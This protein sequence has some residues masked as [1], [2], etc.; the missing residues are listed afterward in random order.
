MNNKQKI[1]PVLLISALGAL[2]NR[3][4]GG[5]LSKGR[6][7]IS[8]W[9]E[10]HLPGPLSWVVSRL[11][12][13]KILNAIVFGLAMGLLSQHW[14]V[15]L[16]S[17]LAMLAGQAPGWGDYIGAAGGWRL[18]PAFLPEGTKLSDLA[19]DSPEYKKFKPLDESPLIDW[20]VEPFRESPV[21][22]GVSGLVLR[23]A[24]WGSCISLA[25]LDIWPLIFSVLM[26]PVYYIITRKSRGHGWERSEIV[27]GAVLWAGAAIGAAT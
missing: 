9:A 11:V 27:F 25:I 15:G 1:I 10:R 6:K 26:G 20:L 3:V 18:G 22:W 13:G 21:I 12:D 4:R 2:L 17:F 19:T 8:S 23:G 16:T 7:S 5:G 14:Y 24:L